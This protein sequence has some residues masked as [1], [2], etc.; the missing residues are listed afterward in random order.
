MVEFIFTMVLMV[1]LSSVLYLMVRALPRV[2][3]ESAERN[4]ILDRWAHSEIP[5]RV[6]AV[7]NNFLVKFLRKVKVVVLKLDNTIAGHL[8]KVKPEDEKKPLIDFKE[9]AGVSEDRRRMGR[10]ASDREE[11]PPATP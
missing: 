6:D 9:I 8:Q 7:L 11:Q 1:C 4:S 10:R 2:A 5:E 3:E